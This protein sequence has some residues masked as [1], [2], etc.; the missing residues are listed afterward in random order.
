MKGPLYRAARE[1][2]L[3]RQAGGQSARS[4]ISS[5]SPGT[6]GYI[7]IRACNFSSPAPPADREFSAWV[8]L[9]GG[10][11]FLGYV[12]PAEFEQNAG[13]GFRLKE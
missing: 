1:K 13:K 2:P 12:P 3:V 5:S 9:E 10:D 4:G 11:Q 6:P 7:P 8:R